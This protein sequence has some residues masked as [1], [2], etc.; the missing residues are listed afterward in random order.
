MTQMNWERLL[1]PTRL[2]DQRGK[3]SVGDEIGRSPFHKDHDRIVFAGS[4]RDRKSVV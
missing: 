2:H 3:R 1:D 4:F